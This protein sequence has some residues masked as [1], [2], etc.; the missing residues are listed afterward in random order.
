[1]KQ[2]SG[3]AFK[4]SAVIPAFSEEKT[5]AKVVKG[6]L[7]YVDEVL[8]V[9]DGSTD[10]T[11]VNAAAA[12]ARVIKLPRNMGVL[13][14]TERGLHEA[15]GDI[16]VTLD[17]DGQHDPSEIPDLIQLIL[18]GK[19]DLVMGR[20]PSFPHLSEQIIAWLT[21][22]RAPVSD[23]STGFRA[24]KGSIARKMRLHGVCLCGTFVLEACRLGARVM[25]VPVTIKEREQGKRRI[26]TR[27][28]KQFFIL[29]WDVLWFKETVLDDQ[30]SDRRFRK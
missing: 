6:C 27:H 17:A 20:R 5:I 21:S 30:V 24:V 29:L 8:V 13:K 28:V 15:K 7:H 18:E 12:G 4:V 11:S 16:I 14:A 22:F 19:A 9:D 3:E 1:M 25:E 10:D 23:A 26:Q 2:E